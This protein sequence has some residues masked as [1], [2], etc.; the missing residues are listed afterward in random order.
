MAR[1]GLPTLVHQ[2]SEVDHVAVHYVVMGSGPPIVFLHGWGA[3]IASFGPI[4]ML[5]ADQFQVVALDLPGFGKTPA[6]D[7]PWGTVD[8][9]CFVGKFL[10]TLGITPV[11]L[12]GHSRGG[13]IGVVLAAQEPELVSKLVLVDSAGIPPY[14][15]PDYYAR[16]Y[17]VKS[18]RRALSLPGLNWLREPAMG[19]LYRSIGSSDYQAATDPVMRA[20]LVK[21]VNDDLREFLP[22]IQAPTLLV[23]GSEDKDTPLTDG[24]LMERL[25]PDA[26][27]VVFGGAGHF[28]YLD[29]LDQFCRVLRHFVEH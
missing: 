12:V 18:V 5:L 13:G 27:L 17:L 22:R 19:Q 7:R 15:G 14:H 29:R 8:Y 9:A 4:P 26:G 20:T 11:T 10:S 1:S 21:V 28:A 6:P 23:W 24:K 2:F 3:E 16:V 25:I